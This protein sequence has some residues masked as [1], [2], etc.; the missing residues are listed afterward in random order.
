MV[1]ASKC[2]LKKTT[3]GRV[4]CASSRVKRRLISISVASI[5]GECTAQTSSDV[6]EPCRAAS[7]H[8]LTR[9]ATSVQQGPAILTVVI[10]VVLMLSLVLHAPGVQRPLAV[11]REAV[12]G[13]GSN[14]ELT[15]QQPGTHTG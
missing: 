3:G 9:L 13:H 5:S 1:Q 4:A 7:Y 8:L 6:S 12:L 10:Q 2:R 15:G 14:K 11:V